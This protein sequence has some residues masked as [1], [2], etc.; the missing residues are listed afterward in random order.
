MAARAEV[1]GDSLLRLPA[2]V[3]LAQAAALSRQW[4]TSLRA[5]AVA[6]SRVSRAGRVMRA[7]PPLA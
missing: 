1:M 3:L 2:S 7:L 4:Q 6:D 5:E